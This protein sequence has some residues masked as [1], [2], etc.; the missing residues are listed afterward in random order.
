MKRK[1]ISNKTRFEVFKRDSFKCQYCGKSAPEAILRCDHIQPVAKGGDNSIM[2]LITAC[3]ECNSGKSDVP[4]ADDAA[5]KKQKEQ[6]DVINER[7]LQLEMMC[8]WRMSLHDLKVESC[9][10][11]TEFFETM[12]NCS[13][14]PT[15]L[16]SMERLVHQFGIDEVMPA[17]E[18]AGSYYTDA[19]E[20]LNK[21]GG[22][23]RIKR[24]EKEN[25]ILSKLYYIRGIL[26]KREIRYSDWII[27]DLAKLNPD[28]ETIQSWISL[29]KGVRNWT[30]F[31][32]EVGI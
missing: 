12:F 9:K 25:P 11:A 1:A 31:R 10:K 28:A 17:I 20:A 26:R 32:E 23:C 27:Q 19:S 4:L 21:V 16:K 8:K 6:M 13:L 14:T 15:G 18:T 5:I 29:A 24:L 30:Q 2:N 22:I 7:R 3:F